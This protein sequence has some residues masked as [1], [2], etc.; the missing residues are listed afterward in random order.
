L[1]IIKDE[2]GKFQMINDKINF[3]SNKKILAL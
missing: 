1:F 3:V 2:Q